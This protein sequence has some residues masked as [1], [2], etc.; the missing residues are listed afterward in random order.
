MYER[1]FPAR[2]KGI[3]ECYQS[4]ATSDW[5]AGHYFYYTVPLSCVLPNFDSVSAKFISDKCRVTDP[6]PIQ[7]DPDP[8]F[9][10]LILIW[11]RV[12]I[13]MHTRILGLTFRSE[14]EKNNLYFL[15]SITRGYFGDFP[16]LHVGTV[17]NTAS[18]AAPQNPLCRRMLNLNPGPC[19]I[20]IGSQ[21]L[22]PLR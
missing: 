16:S 19:N 3:G 14:K 7:A 11:I 2:R 12:R 13:R 20:C 4:I 10:K 22:Q 8:G 6:H 15:N 5:C 21:T 18:S 17:F 9:W 1:W